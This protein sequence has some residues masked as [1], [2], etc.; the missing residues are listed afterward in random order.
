MS[1]TVKYNLNKSI[2]KEFQL[3]CANCSGRTTHKVL[4]SVDVRGDQ[5]DGNFSFSWNTD[6]QI[7]Q[8]QGC[9]TISFRL[10]S[11]NSEENNNYIEDGEVIEVVNE[12]L[13]PSRLEGRK[14]LSDDLYYLPTKVRQI[15]SETLQALMNQSPILAGIGLRALLETVCIEKDA[16]GKDLIKKIDNLVEQKIL[17]P[18]S[19]SILHKI[20][21][22][23]NDA[24]HKVKPHTEK[25]LGLAMD[26][27]E[28]LLRDVYILP[29]KMNSE[30]DD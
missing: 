24:A 15:Y 4:A 8:C 2:D 26:V 28:N 19:A 7:V 9:K 22:L 25:Q 14:G 11:S 17:T 18:A 27:V 6:N 20:R 10:A 5:N 23:G 29:K 3:P 12:T 13:Y 21:T 16:V 30:F 1:E